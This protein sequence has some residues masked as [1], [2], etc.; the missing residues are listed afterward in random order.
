[1]E[2][3]VQQELHIFTPFLS[4]VTSYTAAVQHQNQG[5]DIGVIYRI[6]SDF[7]SFSCSR[8]CVVLCYFIIYLD[9]YDH[10]HQDTESSLTTEELPLVT[11]SYC[12]LSLIPEP[13]VLL[14]CSP[15]LQFCHFQNVTK[16]ES[17]CV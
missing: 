1:M 13:W 16:M 6:Y 2:K 9:L 14:V 12:I 10:H 7:T 5:S 8:V 17:Y 15:S 11:L 4:A 3:I